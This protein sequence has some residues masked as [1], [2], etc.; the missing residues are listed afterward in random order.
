M[1]IAL[2]PDAYLPS[3]TLVHAKMFHELALELKR[4][5]HEPII[6]TP[7]APEQHTALVI[8]HID[9]VE[10]WRFRSGRTR[11][12]GKARRAI[13]E[14]LLSVRAWQAIKHKV[15]AEPFEFCINYSPTI[16][17]GPLA[18]KLKKHGAYVYLILR[19]MFPQWIIDEGLIKEGSPIARY[20]RYFEKL[21]YQTSDCIGVMSE[22]N[23][24]LFNRL[25]PG[26]SNV[27]VLLNWADTKPLLRERVLTNWRSEWQLQDKV[28][29]FYGGNI[30]HAQDMA[31]LMRL[32]KGM[33]DKPEAHFLFVGQGDEVELI[34]QLKRN[35]LLD[36]VTIKPS[37]SQDVYR[38]LLTA[39]DVGLFSL[40]AKHT[41]HNFPG[42]LL[43]YMS[44]SLPILGSVNPGNDVIE[45]IN[46]SN[47]GFVFENGEDAA[48]LAAADLLF[49][50]VEQR[51]QA[52]KNARL[53]LQ[54][55]FS[56]ESAVDN[57][58]AEAKKGASN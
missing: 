14:S 3:S 7:G 25:H 23:L 1:K 27:K 47:S 53:L 24:Q 54:R 51:K 33:K 15:K 30:G 22:A 19:D 6:I 28:V 46:G 41:A 44:E 13:A 9:G 49:E 43:G 4:S 42:K 45:V 2:L 39:V 38:E 57:I 12:V 36:N 8:D 11:G 48:L 18:R 34:H 31:N 29:F 55:Y 5:G 17:F 16:F 21:N 26:Y 32:A 50:S 52:G 37:V 10:I 58:L 35:W 56:V 20:F 40:S